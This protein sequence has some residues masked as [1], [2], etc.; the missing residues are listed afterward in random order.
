LGQ[1]L[2][3]AIESFPEDINVAIV[4]TGG[5]SHQGHGEGCGFNNPDWGA[6][7]GGMLGNEPEKLTEMALGEYAALGGVE[8]A[9]GGEGGGG[10]G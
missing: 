7:V 4:A 2:R 9:E 1:A 5:L 8:G 10:R 3:R 6:Q